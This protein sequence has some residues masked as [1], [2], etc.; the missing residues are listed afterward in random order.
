MGVS[1]DWLE[2]QISDASKDK[3]NAV[4]SKDDFAKAVAIGKIVA[5]RMVEKEVTKPPQPKSDSTK[6]VDHNKAV[7]EIVKYYMNNADFIRQFPDE[8]IRQE[9]AN[10][11]AI[12]AV[13]KQ[14][15]RILEQY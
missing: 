2:R 15:Q 13:E 9:K 6:E 11:I 8:K 3:D 7:G 4:E 10:D 12:K 14:R 1:K 5:F